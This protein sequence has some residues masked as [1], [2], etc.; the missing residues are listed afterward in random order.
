MYNIEKRSTVLENA[1]G[2]ARLDAYIYG[3]V[4]KW[5][6]WDMFIHW[7]NKLH[8]P[9][10]AVQVKMPP[11]L[12]SQKFR[13]LRMSLCMTGTRRCPVSSART[14]QIF[15]GK[16]KKKNKYFELRNSWGCC[17]NSNYLLS[18]FA[19]QDTTTCQNNTTT[20]K[21]DEHTQFHSCMGTQTHCAI[22]FLSLN[23]SLFRV[24]P[25]NLVSHARY[26]AQ[27]PCISAFQDMNT[28]KNAVT[29]T[30]RGHTDTVAGVQSRQK[31]ACSSAGD[32]SYFMCSLHANLTYV[33]HSQQTLEQMFNALTTFDITPVYCSRQCCE[34]CKS[35]SHKLDTLQT[36]RVRFPRL[37]SLLSLVRGNSADSADVN[38][39]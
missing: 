24:V 17:S 26:T 22:I 36:I 5:R 21:N 37:T 8:V 15:G 12:S 28:S 14:T 33:K 20:C 29:C 7:G 18:S 32:E 31:R 1:A 2:F 25:N 3:P 4:T 23:P 39:Q 11:A 34:D 38:I 9:P 35:G 16:K 27:P 10:N 30:Q 6:H 19:S 13:Y